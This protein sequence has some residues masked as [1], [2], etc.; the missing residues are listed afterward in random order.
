MAYSSVKKPAFYVPIFD[1]LQSIGMIEYKNDDLNDIHLLNE[2]SE[3]AVKSPV[4]L[5]LPLTSNLAAGVLVPMPTLPPSNCS[6]KSRAA[7]A[8]F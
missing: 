4:N 2:T 7:T 1:Y 5:P 3:L 6:V 8:P